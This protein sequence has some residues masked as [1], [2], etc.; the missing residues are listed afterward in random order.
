MDGDGLAESAA[1][2]HHAAAV[3]DSGGSSWAVR[4]AWH[5]GSWVERGLPSVVALC[6]F[7]MLL[8]SLFICVGRADFNFVFY[9]A[10]YY[11]W[12][13]DY[14]PSSSAM[15]VLMAR[16]GERRRL[17]VGL[18]PLSTARANGGR[19]GGDEDPYNDSYYDDTGWR[20][21]G[22]RGASQGGVMTHKTTLRSL[23]LLTLL[24]AVASVADLFWISVE[25][26]SWVCDYDSTLGDCLKSSDPRA[27]ATHHLHQL[28]T[29]AS[30]ANLALKAVVLA[31][32]VFWIRMTKR[33]NAEHAAA[34]AVAE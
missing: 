8:I 21:G 29:S 17:P 22:P 33:R 2:L 11:L 28:V 6:Y 3:A 5:H 27:A 18:D 15:Q 24:V 34:A 16:M 23:E 30:I 32:S 19:Y 9:V 4:S 25:T 20:G 13:I 14:W 7:V 1:A 31:M 10:G 12:R 26:S